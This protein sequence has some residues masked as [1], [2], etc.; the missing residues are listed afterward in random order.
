M[1]LHEVESAAQRQ[2][3]QCDGAVGG[4]HRAD[5][6]QV[7]GQREGLGGVLKAHLL[8]AVFE[9]EVEL[10]EHLGEVAPVDLVD[11]QE[12]PLV[13]LRPRLFGRGE[14]RSVSE[15]ETRLPVPQHGTEALHEVLVGIGGMELHQPDAFR[16][17]RQTLRQL[18]RDIGL[19]RTRRPL[20]HDLPLVGQQPLYTTKKGTLD[21][22]LIGEPLQPAA[23]RFS[24]VW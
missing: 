13:R 6:V 22:Q 5:E 24:I 2:V 19:P 11:D 17:P 18:P 15:L 23:L 3:Y 4:I 9:Q 7:V 12:V 1:K 16:R 14:Q 10:A 8:V 21:E 20:E